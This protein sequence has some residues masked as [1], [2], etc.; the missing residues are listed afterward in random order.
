MTIEEFVDYTLLGLAF[1][2]KLK[3]WTLVALAFISP[4][5]YIKLNPKAQFDQPFE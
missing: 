1:R 3:R 5:A 2:R 4:K